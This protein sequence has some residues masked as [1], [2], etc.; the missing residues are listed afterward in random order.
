MK[1]LLIPD[2]YYKDIYSINYKLLKEKNI[3]CL[4]F[5]L[6]NTISP[7]F[8]KKPTKEMILHFQKLDEMGF[9]VII[10]SNALKRRVKPFKEI[11]N[12]DASHTSCK[13][14]SFKYKKIMK[15]YNYNPE[16]IAAIGDQIYTDIKGANKINITSIL[17]NPLSPRESIFT[18]INRLKENKLFKKLSKQKILIK[19]EYYE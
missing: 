1:K 16:Q 14:L 10:I 17:V 7:E 6:D 12:V 4:L 8:I 13:P 9:K 18:K 15:I 2:M 11:L 5:D 3:K 19:G